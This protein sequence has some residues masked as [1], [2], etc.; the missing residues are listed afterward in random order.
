MDDLSY[1]L[2]YAWDLF[3][4]PFTLYGVTFSFRQV[5]GWGFVLS[6]VLW[7]FA[8]YLDL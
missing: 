1:W 2:A 5:F 6:F 8:M 4:Y 3:G 7:G